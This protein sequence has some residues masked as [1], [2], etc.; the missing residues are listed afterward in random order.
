MVRATVRDGERERERE[1]EGWSPGR[2]GQGGQ[3][4][5]SSWT[6]L[7]GNRRSEGIVL[8][9]V[10]TGYLGSPLHYTREMES[11]KIEELCRL[12]GGSLLCMLVHSSPLAS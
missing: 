12:G 8:R 3:G 10:G 5:G 4:L 1:A 7:M 11:L 6:A 9:E 2:G